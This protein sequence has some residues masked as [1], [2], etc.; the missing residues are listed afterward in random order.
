[1]AASKGSPQLQVLI[2]LALAAL[3][4]PVYFIGARHSIG[5]HFTLALFYFLLVVIACWRLPMLRGQNIGYPLRAISLIWFITYGLGP[6]IYVVNLTSEALLVV[7]AGAMGLQSVAMGY[8][9]GTVLT[10]TQQR[11]LPRRLIVNSDSMYR[12]IAVIFGLS[13]IATFYFLVVGGIPILHAD[14]L[15]Y[16]FEV[17]DRVSSYV[18]FVMRAGQLPLYFFWAAFLLGHVR[19]TRF[20]KWSIVALMAITFIVNA[21]P[22][23]RNPL[24]LIAMALLFVYIY[25]RKRVNSV[26]I[27][28]Y[29]SLSVV[30]VVAVGY[31]R[32]VSFAETQRSNTMAWFRSHGS[33]TFD[34]VVQF[35]S[36]QFSSY[37]SGFIAALQ[38]FPQKVPYM[39]GGVF[40]TTI[41]TM[42]PGKQELLDDKLKRWSG[43]HFEGGGLNLSLLGESYADF[44]W[45]GVALYPFLYGLLLGYLIVKVEQ[46]RTP[47]R[48]VTAAFMTT[49]ICIGS[50]TGLLSLSQFWV[51]GAIMMWIALGERWFAASTRPLPVNI[52]AAQ[53]IRERR[54]AATS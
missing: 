25:S 42:L 37:S 1:M 30:V 26:A 53:A 5:F 49:S 21:I 11:Q 2:L 12:R 38:T 15:T 31:F 46:A 3:A 35:V 19:K 54:A 40:L 36:S 43:K 45:V 22:G 4:A 14:A 41:A 47:A 27:G 39:H 24:M 51:L 16:R 20:N 18:L 29:A 50:L 8:I 48:V 9:V 23:W 7:Y 17:R 34:V 52:P 44:G 13:I 6:E 32:L 33:G 10:S 28:F